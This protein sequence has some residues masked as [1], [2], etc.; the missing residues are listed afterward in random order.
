MRGWLLVVALGGCDRVLGLGDI[1]P[2]TG[3]GS[4]ATLVQMV[5][6]AAPAPSTAV[7]LVL[8]QPPAAHDLLVLAVATWHNTLDSVVDS[9]GNMYLRTPVDPVTSGGHSSLWILYASDV[10]TTAPFSI[11]ITT[12]PD[13]VVPTETEVSAAVHEYTGVAGAI[14]FDGVATATG[15][16]TG[17][18]VHEACGSAMLTGDREIEFAA[19]THDFTGTTA[20]GADFTLRAVATEDSECCVALVTEDNL[21]T[22][23]PSAS[24]TTSVLAGSDLAWACA[25]VTFPY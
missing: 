5:P 11:Q 13:P 25:L 6:A 8:G 10:A 2:V 14:P 17:D 9:A 23:A 1:K 4:T 12:T 22:L 19:L 16:G 3:A 7:S 24:F 20:A 18:P 15:A 21:R